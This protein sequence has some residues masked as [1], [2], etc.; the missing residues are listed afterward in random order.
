MQRILTKRKRK[1]NNLGVS[2]R[3][4]THNNK[5]KSLNNKGKEK[6]MGRGELVCV[7]KGTKHLFGDGEFAIGRHQKGNIFQTFRNRLQRGGRGVV[8]RGSDAC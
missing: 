5:T 7:T 4:A 2:R 8:R 1:E 3:G 6:K